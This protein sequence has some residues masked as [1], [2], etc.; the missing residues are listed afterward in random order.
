MGFERMRLQAGRA[1]AAMSVAACVAAIV[2]GVNA[3]TA[4]AERL[5]VDAAMDSLERVHA[6]SQTAISPD[7]RRVAWVEPQAAPGGASTIY[8]RELPSAAPKRVSAAPAGQTA[9][10]TGVAWAPDGRRLAFLSD[11]ET[12][13]QLQIYVADADG[14]SPRLVTHV[15]GQVT[16]PRWSPDGRQIAFLYVAGS[17]QA[18]GALV[19]Y[20]PDAG[21]VGDVVEEQR[22]AVADVASGAVREVSAPN[23]FVYDYD[24]SPDG[25]AFA[26][27]AVEGSG[28]NNYWIAQ[29]YVVQA[30]TGATRS[31]WKPPLQTGGA[32]VVARRQVDR[33]DPRLDERRRLQRRRRLRGAG[34]AAV[35]RATRRPG[36]KARPERCSWRA[37]G[38]IVLD[39]YVDGQ[40]ALV[41]VDVDGG[42]TD[43]AGD[44]AAAVRR[45]CP[46]RDRPMRFRPLCSR[47]Q[48]H[49][50]CT[51]ALSAS[52][53]VRRRST[54]TSSRSGATCEACT[55]RATAARC[56]AGSCTR[57]SFDPSR[58][59]PMVVSVHGGPSAANMAGWPARWNAVLPSQG[60]FVLLPNP[61]GSYGERRGV[62]SGQRQG[63][64]LR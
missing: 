19:A 29:L 52:G 22:I 8:V 28:T 49:P 4:T 27:E 13:G 45:R 32:A 23:M 9:R 39:E 56:R 36:S 10:E 14:G 26:A 6:F 5:S 48:P 30:D 34:S 37:N 16:A 46:S 40:E 33:R 63:L 61:R 47:S 58:R 62:H 41:S 20:K 11:A 31:I 59:Y 50:R 17:S 42:P 38:Q 44:R 54:G 3:R 18:T 60:Y 55:G 51:R 2:F 25:R 21:V 1:V 7:G 57:A 12:A 35:R 53:R 24:W 15:K 64:R 43:G